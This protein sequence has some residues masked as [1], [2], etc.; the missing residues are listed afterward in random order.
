MGYDMSWHKLPAHV[1]AAADA[2][3]L[4]TATSDEYM[5]QLFAF[6]DLRREAGAY[7]RLNIGGMAVWSDYMALMGMTY[8]VPRGER[9]AF[10]VIGDF[11]FTNREDYYEASE[12]E[13]HP[14]RDCWQAYQ[15]AVYAHVSATFAG[16]G[17]PEHKLCTTNDGW[18]VLPEE[19]NLAL[20]TYQHCGGDE[21]ARRIVD[22]HDWDYWQEWL[23][24]LRGAATEGEGFRV[25]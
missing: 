2:I 20:A 15:D 22:P 21:S 10:P 18:H 24:F 1:Q 12:N 17:I 23:A 6:L 3:G 5:R 11:G 14:L 19:I 13:F 16:P 7:F 8:Y 4:S 9:G 25:W